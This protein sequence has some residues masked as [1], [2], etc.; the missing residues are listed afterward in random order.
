MSL[1]RPAMCTWR[2]DL[3]IW[4]NRMS[5]KMRDCKTRRHDPARDCTGYFRFSRS[6]F[7]TDESENGY[8]RRPRNELKDEKGVLIRM[9][10]KLN[11]LKHEGCRGVHHRVRCEDWTVHLPFHH[12]RL[13]VYTIQGTIYI[14]TYPVA[15]FFGNSLPGKQTGLTHGAHDVGEAF[16]SQCT[17]D[18]RGQVGQTYM[19]RRWSFKLQNASVCLHNLRA[20]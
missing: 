16:E 12:E 7:L 10:V 19:K 13:S 20:M 11:V 14:K 5:S 17:T 6:W 4:Q 18:H 15:H 8:R 2:I 9:K 3:W 1:K